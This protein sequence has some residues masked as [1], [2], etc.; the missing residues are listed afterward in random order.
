MKNRQCVE[1]ADPLTRSQMWLPI[2]QIKLYDRNPRRSPNPKYEE[3][4]ES[5]RATRGANVSFSVTRRPGESLYM[6]DAGGNTRLAIVKELY[7]ETGDPAYARLLLWFV[8]WENESSTLKKHLE[9]NILRG[10]VSFLDQSVGFFEL[11][12]EW[13]RESGETISDR[14]FIALLEE[15]G[16]KKAISRA[17]VWR[18]KYAVEEL[19]HVLPMALEA[20]L[21]SSHVEQL[22]RYQTQYKNY[23]QSKGRDDEDA[24]L[25]LFREILA[26]LDEPEFAVE[27]VPDAVEA[28]LAK[29]LGIQHSQVRQEM[30]F[31]R[32]R[33]MAGKLPDRLNPIDSNP[34]P[35]RS[36][37]TSPKTNPN[38]L[39]PDQDG[40]PRAPTMNDRTPAPPEAPIG[41]FSPP[42]PP[43]AET[44]GHV[45]AS[46]VVD[47]A[48]LRQQAFKVADAFASDN[49]LAGCV[50]S[51]PV[52]LGFHLD[53][54][55]GQFESHTQEHV[56]WLLL[57][58]S[59]QLSEPERL[60]KLPADNRLVQLVLNNQEKEVVAIVGSRPSVD[61]LNYLFL[62]D[63][64]SD[65]SDRNYRAFF[66]LTGTC[67]RL[68]K[69]S[70]SA[71]EGLWEGT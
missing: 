63:V 47:I 12:R 32:T 68:L 28:Q 36:A 43:A 33:A 6:V 57:S 51:T 16:L 25:A 29:H 19:L 58:A 44:V 27:I 59:E 11:R 8:P 17:Q 53:F 71:G 3:I 45:A 7:A 52:G 13:E 41:V 62:N 64:S 66:T 35:T 14:G 38:T 60:A 55:G 56:W 1:V 69:C 5:I 24:L 54:P 49:G 42:T 21:G 15:R 22:S 37:P 34:N 67:R 20:G 30:D 39:E 40:R 70:S 2:D 18:M 50:R 65:L 23:W 26:A 31:L 10:D 4:K 61:G 48:T 9:E 46:N